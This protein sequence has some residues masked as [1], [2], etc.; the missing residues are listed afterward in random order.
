MRL[1]LTLT[2]TLTPTL[3]EE[4]RLAS[5]LASPATLLTPS[6]P[7]ALYS[8]PA[9]PADLCTQPATA[10]TCRPRASFFVFALCG[11]FVSPLGA[12]SHTKRSQLRGLYDQLARLIAAHPTLAEHAHFVLVPGPDDATASSPDVL[13]RSALPESVAGE[14]LRAAARN[15][16][17]T[18]NP[19]RLTLC[20]Q[21]VV[22]F[23]EQLMSK[24][25][26]SCV[27]PPNEVEAD[28]GT[29]DLN[30][31]LVQSLLDQ[32][33]LCPLPTTELASYWQ[34]DHAMWLHPSP[35]VLVLADRHDQYQ[36]PYEE[37]LA[38]N[39]GSFASDFAWMVYRPS[40]K[41][42]AERSSLS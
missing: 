2:R 23:R 3:T 5:A 29:S 17:L 19:A 9:C 24:M 27:L 4:L 41:M 18:T 22:I 11:N 35:D 34:H 37:T 15:C 13:P 33:H 26:R 8:R 12:S 6:K 30:A 39:P 31:H 38:F 36:L 14:V 25:R 28:G 1:A 21:S 16:H 40:A 10:C 20:G 32:A 7:A 42:E